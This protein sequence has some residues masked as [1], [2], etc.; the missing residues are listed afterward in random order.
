MAFYYVDDSIVPLRFEL[1]NPYNILV[2]YCR[3]GVVTSTM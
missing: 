3:N 1:V 2:M